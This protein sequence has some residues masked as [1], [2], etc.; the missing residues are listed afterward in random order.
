MVWAKIGKTNEHNGQNKPEIQAH[1]R[2]PPQET[3]GQEWGKLRNRLYKG[4]P[5]TYTP[6]NI[7]SKEQNRINAQT[8]L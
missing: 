5:E 4:I 6:N 7:S 2:Q 8:I 3:T 1:S